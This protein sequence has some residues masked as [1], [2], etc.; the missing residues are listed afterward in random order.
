MRVI[1]VDVVATAEALTMTCVVV[2][3]KKAL[4][5]RGVHV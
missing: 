1:D 5:Y 2:V 4:N 3:P